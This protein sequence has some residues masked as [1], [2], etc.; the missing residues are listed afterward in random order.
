VVGCH[1]VVEYAKT[2]TFL[3][4]ENPMKI[5]VPITVSETI[6]TIGTAGTSGTNTFCIRGSHISRGLK[7]GIRKISHRNVSWPSKPTA[8]SGD[9]I[10]NYKFPFLGLPT[11]GTTGTERSGGT[12][13][14]ASAST[15]VDLPA[16]GRPGMARSATE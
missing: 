5:S 8:D 1:H 6:G 7:E 11:I 2:K 3:G 13:G 4:F 16:N 9:G 12:F 14:T 15:A 10:P